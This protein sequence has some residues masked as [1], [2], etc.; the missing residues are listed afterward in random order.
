M[1]SFKPAFSL[2]SFSF[3]KRL[4]SSFSLSAIRVVTSSYM[5]LWYFSQQSKVVLH[6]AQHFFVMAICQFD[7]NMSQLGLFEFILLE[8]CSA[9]VCRFVLFIR[10]AKIFGN[11]F[12]KDSSSPSHT[13]VNPIM[14]MLIFLILFHRPLRLCSLLVFF[15][16]FLSNPQFR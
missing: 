11:S 12:F 3:I 14:Y 10:F 9:W 1:L 15:F 16:F 2:S 6:P 13:F 4:C 5:R 8:I 7:Y